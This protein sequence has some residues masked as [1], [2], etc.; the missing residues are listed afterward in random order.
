VP[1]VDATIVTRIL[2]AGGT[3]AGK[4]HCEYFC[5]SGGSHTSAAGPVH[6]PYKI[7]YSAGGSS[8]GCAAL[9][10]SGEI[11]MA[12]GG[13]QGGSVRMPS[14]FSGCYGMKATHGLVPYTGA[15]PIE[16]TIDHLGPMTATVADNALLLEAIA[17]ADGLDPRQY[18][19]RVDKYT[20]ALGRGVAGLRIGV[21]TEG[22][23]HAVSEPDVD[24]KVREAAERLR[25]LGAIV[26]EISI[27]MHLDGLAI[28]TPIALEGL[29]AQMMHGNGMGF[30]WQGL[31]TTSLLDAHANWRAR[32]NELSRTLKIS[33][34]GGEYFV[35]QYRGHFYAK[36]Q[37]LVRL[38]R[39]TYEQAFS[40]LDLLLMPTTPMKAT[41]IPPQDAPL[42]LYCQRGFEMLPNTTPFSVCGNPA[43]NV[44]CGLSAGLPVGMQLVAAHYNES[45][46]YRAAHAFEQLGDWRNF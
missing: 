42:S 39:K 31:Y 15:M 16:A 38:L 18:N 28:W 40:R 4:A 41:P 9:V 2:D 46:I 45:T 13:D 32:A 11:E 36:A 20:A 21:L 5:L 26:E 24:Q 30:N 25:A 8:S 35:R 22:F 44:P 27:P 33:M 23:R 34:L 29:Q 37:N 6:N 14:S 3:I 19:V 7:G 12:I 10:G 43:M 1:D 17:G